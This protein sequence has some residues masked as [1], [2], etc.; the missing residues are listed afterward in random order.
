[1]CPSFWHWFRYD[2]HAVRTRF[3]AELSRRL[4]LLWQLGLKADQPFTYQLKNGGLND[5]V[6]SEAFCAAALNGAPP[7]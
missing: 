4:D 5:L 2:P 7:Q 1:L 3:R 6:R